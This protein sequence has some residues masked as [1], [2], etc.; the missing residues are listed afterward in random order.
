MVKKETLYIV[1]LITFGV[2]FLCGV[3]FSAIKSAPMDDG[4]NHPPQ[5]AVVQPQ[6]QDTGEAIRVL[7]QVVAKEPQNYEAW[8]RLGNNY[9]DTDQSE[10][11]IIAY[12]K[13]LAI[14]NGSADVWTD[15]GIMY[16]RTGQFDKA[17]ESFNEG[18]KRQPG[19]I[20]SRF[21][22]GIV[23]LA[24]FNDPA[25]AIAAWEEVLKLDP[26]A[27]AQNGKKLSDWVAELKA[28]K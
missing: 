4:H 19:H 11:A 9:Y 10:K 27:T 1:A 18:A 7:E 14:H 2:G 17:I 26:T 3:I 5:Q 20:Q 23:L 8:V 15:L 24:D 12:D 22:K 25:G 6:Q 21:N 13:A 16:R 28:G